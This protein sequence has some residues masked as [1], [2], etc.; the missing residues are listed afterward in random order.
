MLDWFRETWDVA[1][2]ATAFAQRD[3]CRVTQ[4]RSRALASPTILFS[5]ETAADLARFLKL[6]FESAYLILDAVSHT[7]QGRLANGRPCGLPG[8]G[9]LYVLTKTTRNQP[10]SVALNTNLWFQRHI[11]DTAPITEDLEIQIAEA[12]RAEKRRRQAQATAQEAAG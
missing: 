3:R 8:L 7:M 6:D 1:S 10:R 2:A 9:F 4:G 12:R 5:Q 11:A